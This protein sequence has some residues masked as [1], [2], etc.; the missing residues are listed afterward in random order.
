MARYGGQQQQVF[1]A[2]VMMI[3]GIFH[4]TQESC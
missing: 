2:P 4:Q 3:P 1:S